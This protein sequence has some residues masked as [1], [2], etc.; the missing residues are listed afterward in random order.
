MDPPMVA[1]CRAIVVHVIGLG[2][3]EEDRRHT[4]LQ[5]AENAR[6]NGSIETS[7]A[8]YMHALDIFPTKESIWRE[9]AA[10]EREHG[11]R[12][13]LDQLLREAVRHCPDAEV[14][15]LMA[16]K[17]KWLAGDVTA[18]R[19]IL[20]EAFK[21][22]SNSEEIWLAAFKVEFKNREPE[23]AKVILSKARDTS[24][25]Q[26]S[27]RIWMKSAMVERELGNVQAEREMLEEGIK[28]FP[29]FYKMW[30][31]LGQLER[32]QGNIEAA[33]KAYNSGL[34][35]CKNS[36]SLWR[37]LAKLE[38]DQ[39]NIGKARAVLDRSR[40]VNKNNEEL[41]LAA[42]RLERRSANNTEAS[43]KLAVALK[44]CPTGDNDGGPG[45]L[46]AEA[47]DMAPRHEKKSKSTDAIRACDNNP[48]VV[49]SVARFFWGL[50][51]TEKART[52]FNR[53]VTLD[54]DIGDFW[55]YFYKFELQHGGEGNAKDILRRCK[56]ADPHHG[57][58]WCRVTKAFE[59]AHS[60]FEQVMKAMLVDI[61][62]LPPP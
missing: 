23:R 42:V 15:W 4:W 12:E 38:E 33:R 49:C 22:N 62:T 3:E 60:T 20:E 2:V 39:G 44:E 36:V 10:L 16:A 7:R 8:V 9:A 58:R 28:R 48:F 6:R 25:G 19:Q 56:E 52:W 5:D 18:A 35:K 51:K 30:L 21:V 1:T 29:S 37:E 47:I 24:T 27:E 26:Q 13:S 34:A 17:E 32:R 55:A 54:K 46:W 61:D 41:W 14:L 45:R 11:S 31:M 40:I 59:N 43:N 53:A 50:G 57:E